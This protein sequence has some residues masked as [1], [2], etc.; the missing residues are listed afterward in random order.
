MKTLLREGS[1]HY[2]AQELQ[3]AKEVRMDI[4]EQSFLVGSKSG[5]S[6]FQNGFCSL[7]A[8]QLLSPILDGAPFLIHPSS[9]IF[10]PKKLQTPGQNPTQDSAILLFKAA[11]RSLGFKHETYYLPT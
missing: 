9:L 4:W 3:L 11:P 2:S 5:A 10:L 8:L 1:S 7:I 6:L